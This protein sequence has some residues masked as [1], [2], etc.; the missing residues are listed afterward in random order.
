MDRGSAYSVSTGV[1]MELL[2]MEELD[3]E[4]KTYDKKQEYLAHLRW[5]I[6]D[7]I[8]R[9]TQGAPSPSQDQLLSTFLASGGIKLGLAMS[10]HWGVQL[11][12]PTPHKPQPHV[13]GDPSSRGTPSTSAANA[14][15]GQSQGEMSVDG[16]TEPDSNSLEQF[17]GK[18]LTRL[19]HCESFDA[20]CK[21]PQAP[22][23]NPMCPLQRKVLFTKLLE[24]ERKAMEK[25]TKEIKKDQ[26]QR[27][28]AEV[29]SGHSPHFEDQL[30]HSF[31]ADGNLNQGLAIGSSWGV[32]LTSPSPHAPQRHIH[33][34]S[35]RADTSGTSDAS[36]ATGQ[37]EGEVIIDGET[38]P[39]SDSLR[40]VSGKF[41]DMSV[42]RRQALIPLKDN[43]K[44]A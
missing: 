43:E 28:T 1:S 13:H 35:S 19:M 10:S 42:E 3:H 6:P 27:E 18:F 44:K 40:H 36:A 23:Q 24:E 4:P 37:V 22:L 41:S 30:L 11:D 25:H 26:V 34:G 15:T 7:H 21:Q 29:P 5:R 2:T 16:K 20:N 32:H 12:T 9:E 38:E 33:G 39:D 17:S 14:V 8:Q 31:S